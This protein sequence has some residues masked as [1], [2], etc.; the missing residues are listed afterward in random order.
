MTIEPSRH[1]R[2]SVYPTVGR[3]HRVDLSKYGVVVNGRLVIDYDR[4]KVDNPS[5]YEEIVQHEIN[6]DSE[7]SE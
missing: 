4:L 6:S 1:I 2:S 7:G 3:D 5:L